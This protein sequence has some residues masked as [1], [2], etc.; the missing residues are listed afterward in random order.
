MFMQM[1]MSVDVVFSRNQ[2]HIAGV[3]LST[4]ISPLTLIK[5]DSHWE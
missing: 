1:N 4:H 2:P 3:R 5:C